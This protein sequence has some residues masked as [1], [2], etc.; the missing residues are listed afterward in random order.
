MRKIESVPLDLSAVLPA[1]RQAAY[2][3]LR[4]IVENAPRGTWVGAE[5]EVYNDSNP[6]VV[7]DVNIT[8]IINAA[9]LEV[10]AQLKPAPIIVP[11]PWWKF[12]A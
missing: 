5:P 4:V 12:W 3:E 8:P 1:G 2:A 6:I 9:M 10:V 7:N 11:R